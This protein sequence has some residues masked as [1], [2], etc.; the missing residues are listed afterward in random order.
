VNLSFTGHPILNG[1]VERA[2]AQFRE[3]SIRRRALI[4]NNAHPAYRNG[5]PKHAEKT[6]LAQSSSSAH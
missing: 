1:V 6:G 2:K 4:S 5:H 3:D